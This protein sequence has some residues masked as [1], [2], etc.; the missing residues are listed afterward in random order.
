MSFNEADARGVKQPHNDPLVIMLNIEGFKTKR[1]LVDNGSSAD[2]IYLLAFQQLKLDP[3]RL[4]PFESPFI[5]FSG[6]RVYPRGIV[7]LTVTVGT[8]SRQLTRQL[9]FLVVDCPSSYNV[10]IGRPTLNRWK[11]AMSTYCLKVKFPIDNGVGELRGDQILARECYQAILATRENHTWIIGEEENKVEALE[12]VAPVEDGTAKTTKIGTTLSPE[13]RT[14]LIE[15]LK[16]NLDVFTWS[17]ED[18]P[19]ISPKIIQHKLNIHPERKPVQQRRRAFAFERDQAIAEEVTKLLTAGFIRE[20]YY[21]DWLAN[22]VLVK[23]ANGK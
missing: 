1:I 17:H 23:K 11:A 12:T 9:D 19:G 14:R 13:M 5:S 21:T 4:C 2:I 18:K 22:V 7:T 15:F 3:K 6:D 16:E 8:Q 10:I 20:V